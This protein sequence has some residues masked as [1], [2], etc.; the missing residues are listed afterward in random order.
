MHSRL[1][2]QQQVRRERITDLARKHGVTVQQC[3]AML[4]AIMRN[5][6]KQLPPKLSRAI[7]EQTS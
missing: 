4:A 5:G 2:K 1:Y 7:L 6:G 3:E